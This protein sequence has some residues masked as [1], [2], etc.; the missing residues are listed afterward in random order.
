LALQP[1]TVLSWCVGNDC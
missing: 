1:Y